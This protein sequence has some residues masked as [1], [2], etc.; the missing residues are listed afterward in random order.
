MLFFDKYGN[1]IE[2]PIYKKEIP[3][4]VTAKIVLD[5]YIKAIGGEKALNE[6]KTIAM[7]GTTTIPQAPSPLSFTSKVDTNNKLL[8]ELAM[9]E[10]SMMKQVLNEKEGSI[11][12]QGR[13]M[14]IEGADLA[15]MKASAVPFEELGFLTKTNVEL[16]GI[17][18][19]EGSD[20]YVLKNGDAT[21]Y[22]DAKSGL[23]VADSEVQDQGGNKITLMT[24]YKDYRDVKG[25]KVPFNIVKNVGI[26]LDIKMSDVKI[27]EGVSD[28]D[29]Q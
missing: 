26:E 12:Q 1:S 22:Y 6:V 7:Y 17:E 25:V 28:A 9:G 27:N 4:G 18:T 8:V 21:L 13:K 2:K 24:Y 3:A 5:N 29:F 16:T 11:T 10:M 23:K 20:A 15:K 14:K 19:I